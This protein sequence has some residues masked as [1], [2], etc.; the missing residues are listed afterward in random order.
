[1]KTKKSANHNGKVRVS[2]TCAQQDAQEV[3]IAGSF[4]DWSPSACP[5]VKLENGEWAKQIMLG[6]GRYEYRFVVDG[7]WMSDPSAHDVAANPFGELNSV[8]VVGVPA[9]DT[10]TI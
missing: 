7:C 6:P 5:M 3:C 8:L 10:H 2:F 1:M 9:K 4:N